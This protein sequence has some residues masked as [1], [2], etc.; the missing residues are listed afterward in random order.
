MNNL[1]RFT[2]SIFIAILTASSLTFA[3]KALG[4][5][6]ITENPLYYFSGNSTYPTSLSSSAC[7][8]GAC[9]YKLGTTTGVSWFRWAYTTVHTNQIW[10]YDPTIGESV[11]KY[12]WRDIG[13]PG[14]WSVTVNQA[15]S[16]NKGSWVYLGFSDYYATNSGGYLTLNT[17]CTG[18]ACGKKVLWDSMKYTTFP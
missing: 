5:Y 6:L 7:V 13:L 14:I 17:D 16:A 9:L 11:A 2:I 3:A 1:K 12:T 8:S 15:N 4:P 10:A 18:W